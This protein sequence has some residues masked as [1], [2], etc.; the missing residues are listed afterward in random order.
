MKQFVVIGLGSFGSGVAAKLAEIGNEVL[1]I[2]SVEARV[3][4]IKDRVTQAIVG[5]AKDKDMLREFVPERA[6]AV[7]VSLGDDLEASVLCVLYLKE[8]KAGRIIAKASSDDH[9]RIL[10]SIGIHEVIHPERDAAIRLAEKLSAPTDVIDY[11]TLSPEYSI[12]DVATPDDFVGKS[13]RELH[14]PKRHGVLAIAVKNVLT[15][16]ITLMPGADFTLRPDTVLT[17]IGRYQ[18]LA[19]LSL[20]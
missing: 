18:D 6:D 3:D 12:A 7:I 2:D 1:A 10:E 16:Q 13:L 8:L 5:D 4:D 20:K 11:I 17:L 15:N 14:L 9:G 19:K